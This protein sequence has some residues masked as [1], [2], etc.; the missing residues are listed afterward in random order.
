MFDNIKPFDPVAQ[1]RHRLQITGAVFL[2]LIAGFSYYQLKN[3]PEELQVRR[4]FQALQHQEF[5]KAY[6]LWQPTSSY[7]FKDF[8]QDWGT[9]G[10]NWPIKQFHITGSNERGSGVVVRVM[11]NDK[12]FIS[13]WVEKKNKSLSFPP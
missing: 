9:S 2:V 1:R 8:S 5:Q 10:Q 4:F 13:L 11:V 3:F 12:D 7:T 6:E